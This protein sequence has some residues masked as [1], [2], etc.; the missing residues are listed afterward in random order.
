MYS[1]TVYNIFNV[2]PTILGLLSFNIFIKFGNIVFIELLNYGLSIF[3]CILNNNYYAASV[4]Y[5]IEPYKTT[6]PNNLD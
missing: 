4:F 1:I 5:F 6:L 2:I 3:D